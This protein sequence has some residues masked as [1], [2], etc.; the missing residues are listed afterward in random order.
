MKTP[1]PDVTITHVRPDL[2]PN[3]QSKVFELK[4]GGI[5]QLF[6]EPSGNYFYKMESKTTVPLDQVRQDIQQFLQQQKANQ[7]LDALLESAKP[8][9]NEAYF[10]NTG[11]EGG[12]APVRPPGPG[13]PMP[14]RRGAPQP[15]PVAPP[16]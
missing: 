4:P 16:K 8:E 1:P 15:P 11:A 14:P 7:A 5:S 6:A 12:L 3:G 10:G 9:F 13:G 2:L